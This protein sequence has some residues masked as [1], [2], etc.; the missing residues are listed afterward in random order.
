MAPTGTSA[1]RDPRWL[2]LRIVVDDQVDAEEEDL[3]LARRPLV[4]SM[5]RT[6]LAKAL[7]SK[8][9]KAT[10]RPSYHTR[11]GRRARAPL[12]AALH[13]VPHRPLS[14]SVSQRSR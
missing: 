6:I 3:V 2:A 4:G 7:I 9:R 12:P 11:Y 14:T 5:L 8:S 10:F 13:A 1:Q